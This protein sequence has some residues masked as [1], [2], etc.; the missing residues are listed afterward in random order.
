MYPL[1]S[2]EK[3]SLVRYRMKDTL[4]AVI[5]GD[6]FHNMANIVDLNRKGV[7]FHLACAERELT[8]EFI[9]LDLISEKKRIVLRS[10]LARVVYTRATGRHK[11][12]PDDARKRCGVEFVNLSALEK[13][14]IDLVVKKYALPE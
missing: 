5:Q 8:E 10:L 13:R 1:E 9:L 7:G 14:M 12:N 6:N 3:R 4:F 11:N 2:A